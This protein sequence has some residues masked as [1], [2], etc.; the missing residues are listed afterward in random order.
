MAKIRFCNRCKGEHAKPWDAKCNIVLVSDAEESQQNED[1][2]EVIDS[3][4][5]AAHVASP[6]AQQ[7]PKTS[8]ENKHL[9][10]F[11]TLLSTI[12]TLD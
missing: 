3:Q 9:E 11:N 12:K 10:L 1:I 7:T 5:A 6:K 4:N 8:G 2:G